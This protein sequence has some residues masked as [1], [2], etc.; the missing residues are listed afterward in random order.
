MNLFHHLADAAQRAP[1]RVA[2]YAPSKGVDPPAT[3]HGSFTFGTLLRDAAKVAGGLRALGVGRGDRVV[4]MV[5]VSLEL[6]TVV[7]ALFR[8]GA[9]PVLMDPWMGVARMAECVRRTDAAAFVGIPLAHALMSWRPGL[10]QL[11]RVL[12]GGASWLGGHRLDAML[13]GAADPAPPADMGAGDPALITF[14]GGSTGR[15]KGLLRSHAVLDA[16]HRGTVGCMGVADGDVHMQ[17]FPNMVL[18]NI[19]AGATS[20]IPCYRQ[21]HVAE[22]D[23]AALARQARRF[24][25]TGICGPPALLARLADHCIDRNAP[26][27]QVRRIVVG[28]SAVGFGILARLERATRPG[29]A[30]V[31]YGS[32]EAEPLATLRGGRDFRRARR[33]LREGGG[34]CVGRPPGGLDLEII[35]IPPHDG[36]LRVDEEEL[37]RMQLPPGRVGELLVRGE[38][39]SQGYYRDPEA[40]AAVKVRTGPDRVWHRLGDMGYLDPAGR[41][42]LVGRINDAVEAGGRTVHPLTVEPVIDALP[43]VARAGIV[44]LDER[45]TR[46][47]VVG[48]E[49]RTTAAG[50][51]DRGHR[52]ARI[53]GACQRAGVEVDRV[54]PL[55]RVPVDARHNGKIDHDRLAVLCRRRL[56]GLSRWVG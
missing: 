35:A 10:R 32:S 43:F 45:G 4:L 5:P 49:P 51:E 48:Y 37:R 23:G 39:V 7:A 40:D 30:V 26:L 55:S 16:Q 34:L 12:V 15:P 6:Y 13:A 24:G 52:Q 14:T 21:G 54:I 44:G 19:A 38:H 3:R 56:G 20:V 42:A 50:P 9:I 1:D 2:V 8:L 27:S 33:A 17:A 46:R 25:V 31:L 47:L 29:A 36:P 22:A 18:S 11:T 28:G 53:R 41:I